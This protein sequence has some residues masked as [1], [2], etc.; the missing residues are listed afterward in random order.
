MAKGFQFLHGTKLLLFRI[1][2]SSLEF[3]LSSFFKRYFYHADTPG[4]SVLYLG[5]GGQLYFLGCFSR[6]LNFKCNY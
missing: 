5:K 3:R 4:D 6:V 2:P 1:A